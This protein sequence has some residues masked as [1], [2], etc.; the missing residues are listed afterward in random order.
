M[1]NDA[2]DQAEG[3]GSTTG[4]VALFATCYGNRNDPQSGEDLVAV[5][6][7]N[8]IAVRTADKEQC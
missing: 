1:Q 4:K 6:R 3:A 8:N 5:L 7:H 2:G